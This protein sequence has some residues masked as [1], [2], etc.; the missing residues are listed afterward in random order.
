MKDED[1]KMIENNDEFTNTEENS[2]DIYSKIMEEEKAED[3]QE[4]VE[5]IHDNSGKFV[6][7]LVIIAV[8]LIICCVFYYLFFLYGFPI[9]SKSNESPSDLE[10]NLTKLTVNNN[11]IK[12]YELSDYSSFINDYKE[13]KLPEVYI[14]KFIFDGVDTYK[15]L[16]IDDFIEDGNEV[17]QKTLEATILN[18][19][20]SVKLSGKLKG[21]LAVNTNDLNDDISIVLNNVSIDS[22]SKKIPAIYV[23]NK[24][25]NYSSHKVTIETLEGTTNNIE[26]GKFKK[27]SLIPK[28]ELSNYQNKYTNE[29]ST[30]YQQFTNYYGVY[31]KEQINNILFAK[32]TA[33]EQ[34]LIEGDPYYFY[35]A[36]GAISSDIDL[37]FEGKGILNITSKN[38]EGIESKANL[39]FI[40]GEGEY[41]ISSK[42]DGLNTSSVRTP[43]NAVRNDIFINVKS[44]TSIVSLDAS[45]GDAIDSN[46]KIT[47][48][49]G[50]I[51]ALSKS[52]LDNGIDS[53]EGTYI[54]G[55][56]VLAT[57]DMNTEINSSSKQKTVILS[58]KDKVNENELI[59]MLDSSNIVVFSYLTDRSYG[60]LLYSSAVLNDDN[61]ILYKNGE[62]D[63]S[64]TH[65]LYDRITSFKNGVRLNY[66]TLGNIYRIEA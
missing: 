15:A 21:M 43:D 32:V 53:S 57:G 28:E 26:G 8:S 9:K 12:I 19:S 44:L 55:G 20:S 5:E 18:I 1:Y 14:T 46:G 33:D 64:S 37:Y 47:I 34:D 10:V 40:G 11:S 60:E 49:G 63:G 31:T 48:E 25:M 65:G 38:K 45:S 6:L 36:T 66:S 52:G 54:N 7:S 23:Y 62:V 50:K 3:K 42:D 39:A 16:D 29:F 2:Y 51:I 4:P 61:Y 13:N 41:N 35:K 59:T 58:F 17:E 30:Y 27:I 24:D 56:T 22:D